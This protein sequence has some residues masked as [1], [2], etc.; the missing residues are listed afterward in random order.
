LYLDSRKDGRS[1]RWTLANNLAANAADRVKAVHK[2]HNDEL[3][4][5]RQGPGDA[6]QISIK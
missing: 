1:Q 6:A 5:N 2:A 3:D 4:G